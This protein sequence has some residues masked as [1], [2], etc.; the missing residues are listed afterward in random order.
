[1]KNM[2]AAKMIANASTNEAKAV[3]SSLTDAQRE[4]ILDAIFE[5]LNEA[6]GGQR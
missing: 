1:M 2:D 3:M 4:M 6:C 5:L